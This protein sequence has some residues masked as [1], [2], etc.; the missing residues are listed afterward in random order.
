MDILNKNYFELFNINVSI[1][2]NK[3][4]LDEKVK[5]LQLTFHPDKFI[6]STAR[7]RKIAL[8]ISSHI[9]DGYK[10]LSDIVLRVEYILKINNYEIDDSKTINDENFLQLQ[11]KYSEIIDS[12][13]ITQNQDLIKSNIRDLKIETRDIVSEI[14]ECYEK[15]N[16]HGMWLALS[17]L[18]FFKKNIKQLGSLLTI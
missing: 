10:I 2:L 5:K 12:L 18:R 16:F 3:S 15:S 7:E 11:I 13:N 8:M 9:N 4:I 17:R 14:K 1:D 6:N